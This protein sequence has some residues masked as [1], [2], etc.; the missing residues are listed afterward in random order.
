MSKKIISFIFLMF[1]ASLFYRIKGLEHSQSPVQAKAMTFTELPGWKAADLHRSLSAFTVSCKVFLRQDPDKV[2]GSVYFPLQARDWH[3]VC[4]AL[5]AA[6]PH[7][8]GIRRFFEQWFT[9]VSFQ[10]KKPIQ[11]L[12][13]GYYMPLL[14]GSR[15]K[16]AKYHVPLYAVPKDLVSANLGE[17]RKEYRYKTIAGRVDKKQLIP[18]YTRAQINHGAI[19]D[20][21][22]VILWI[23]DEVE[24]QFLEIEGSGVV[25]LANGEQ[26]Y[27]GYAGQNGNPYQSLAQILIDKGVMTRDNASMQAIKKYLAAHPEEKQA[28]L[29]QNPSF[30]FFHILKQKAAIGAQGVGLTPGISLAVDRQ[31]VPMGTPLWLNTAHP[32]TDES[33]SKPFNRLMIAQDTGGAIKGPVRG[34]VYWGA[35]DKAAHVAGHMKHPGH[36]WLLLPNTALA[37]GIGGITDS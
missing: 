14:H 20:K 11:G 18:Y 13:T 16:S 28:I 21:A 24:R 7:G 27:V 31:W 6:K 3:P 36:Y 33:Q 8:Q 34:D 12:F 17:F 26:V 15:Q 22:K 23:D 2:V 30:V 29:N 32:D 19:A 1:F 9:P 4:K 5:L 25:Q 10:Q 37:R 35:G